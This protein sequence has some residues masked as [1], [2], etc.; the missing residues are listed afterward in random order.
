MELR[1]VLR[2]TFDRG[3]K[4]N[5][6]RPGLFLSLADR[7]TL[8]A[9]VRAD[10][11]VCC[12]QSSGFFFFHCV[13]TLLTKASH[14]SNTMPQLGG[15]LTSKVKEGTKVIKSGFPFGR[16][17]IGSIDKYRHDLFGWILLSRFIHKVFH[18]SLESWYFK[19]GSHDKY[20]IDFLAEIV[21]F[22]LENTFCC[23]RWRWIVVQY[24]RRFEC[25]IVPDLLNRSLAL[26]LP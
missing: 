2:K 4:L 10:R 7:P 26:I 3:R 12:S 14:W 8:V 19:T 17:N 13:I 16:K 23:T 15:Y 9:F 18:Q 20:E 21:F 11:A 5:L 25:T 24:D 6:R 22:D 1:F